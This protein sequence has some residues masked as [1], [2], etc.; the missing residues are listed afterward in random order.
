MQGNACHTLAIPSLFIWGSFLA[1]ENDQWQRKQ[2][3]PKRK[4]QKRSNVPTCKN[5]CLEAP[6]QFWGVFFSWTH[7]FLSGA[8]GTVAISLGLRCP[9]Y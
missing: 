8:N 2:R 7:R 6:Q 3:S 5:I 9:G 4:Q 1:K